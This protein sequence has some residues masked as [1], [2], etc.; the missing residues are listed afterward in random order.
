MLRAGLNKDLPQVGWIW[1]P[2]PLWISF[3]QPTSRGNPAKSPSVA[4]ELA[5]RRRWTTSPRP[6]RRGRC[7]CASDDDGVSGSSP[8]PISRSP[9]FEGPTASALELQVFL[10]GCCIACGIGYAYACARTLTRM[11]APALR[12]RKTRE[13]CCKKKYMYIMGNEDT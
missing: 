2:S 8:S 5:G 13:N 11:C 3:L 1:S 7:S 6:R 12:L 4:I 10:T 9:F